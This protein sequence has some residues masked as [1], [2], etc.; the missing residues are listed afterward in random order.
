MA[1]FQLSPL[2]CFPTSFIKRVIAVVAVKI[3]QDILIDKLP[4]FSTG[5][6]ENSSSF[7]RFPLIGSRRDYL[8]NC[9]P[10]TFE[11]VTSKV[12]VYS[13]SAT[14]PDRSI[15]QR[16]RLLRLHAVVLGEVA[17]QHI[18]IQSDHRADAPRSAMA[19]SMSSIDT[20]KASASSD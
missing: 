2:P 13:H 9:I 14:Y 11:A 7:F 5:K 12:A 16:R 1:A 17:N 19:R 10:A 6:P 18:R 8:I 4:S 15:R 3:V 20:A